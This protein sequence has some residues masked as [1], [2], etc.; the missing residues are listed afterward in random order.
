[1]LF[2]GNF[3]QVIH[4]A[5]QL[6][7]QFGDTAW[8]FHV[9]AHVE[10][11]VHNGKVYGF[12]PKSSFALMHSGLPVHFVQ[13]SSQQA[14]AR[15][16]DLDRPLLSGSFV[17]RFANGFWPAYMKDENFVLPL[18]FVRSDGTIDQ[19]IMFQNLRDNC[20]SRMF[21]TVTNDLML[22]T[23]PPFE[24]VLNLYNLVSM[25][26]RAGQQNDEARSL[27]QRLNSSIDSFKCN[28]SAD[29]EAFHI[30]PSDGKSE[31][32]CKVGRGVNKDDLIAH[33]YEVDESIGE[34]G[35]MAM[36]DCIRPACSFPVA[37]ASWFILTGCFE[38]HV[39]RVRKKPGPGKVFIAKK[40][41]VHETQTLKAIHS[42]CPSSNLF[43]SPVETCG[44]PEHPWIILPQMSYSLDTYLA[45]PS[46]EAVGRGPSICWDIIAALSCLPLDLHIAHRDIRPSNIVLDGLARAKLIDFHIAIQVSDKNEEVADLR[47]TSGWMAPEVEECRT[48]SPIKANRWACGRL[49]RYLLSNLR[50]NDR[51]L[52]SMANNLMKVNPSNRPSLATYLNMKLEVESPP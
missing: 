6:E 4:E 11:S 46:N 30:P 47:V 32:D 50:V 39:F 5:T 26:G 28:Q 23:L 22:T 34:T 31:K 42:L 21:T 51:K 29:F 52:Y 15:S 14:R 49:I 13:V 19:Y 17:V 9:I 27:V 41:S 36:P 3:L 18:F 2:T 45:L 16:S 48:H 43:I 25:F 35:K 37:F 20:D 1:M 40:T 12:K 44:I 7:P 24:V 8:P 10:N 33:G 38:Q